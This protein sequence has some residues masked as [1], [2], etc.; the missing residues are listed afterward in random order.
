MGVLEA[1]GLV[2]QLHAAAPLVEVVAVVLFSS[3]TAPL[4]LAAR[5]ERMHRED[6]KADYAR[7]D[8]VAADAAEASDKARE[9]AAAVAEQAAEAARLLLESQEQV[10]AHAEDARVQAEEAA[11][12]LLENNEL[13]ERTSAGISGK[14]GVIHD[15]VNSSMTAAMQAEL[16][17]TRREL[18]MM[19]EVVE[20]NRQ[21]G[22]E[23]T[24]EALAAIEATSAR[25]MELSA[26]LRDRGQ[27]RRPGT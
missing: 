14:L 3:V 11:R 25:I 17:A 27:T 2:S 23:P 24:V 26:A 15:L 13:V 7:Q 9:A 20:L 18:A 21:A 10:A 6:R 8:K 12:L 22:R 4:I 19:R 1:G 5:T 16:D